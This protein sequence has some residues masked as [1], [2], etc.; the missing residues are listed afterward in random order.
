MFFSCTQKLIRSTFWL[1]YTVRISWPTLQ[2]FTHMERHRLKK[3]LKNRIYWC[4]IF[5]TKC[6]HQMKCLILNKANEIGII[7]SP[8]LYHWH[9]IFRHNTFVSS[10]NRSILQ[11]HHRQSTTCKKPLLYRHHAITS[12]GHLPISLKSTI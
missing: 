9:R 2:F 7:A 6:I 11:S 1:D 12:L 4:V 3:L 8:S 10:Q 5:S